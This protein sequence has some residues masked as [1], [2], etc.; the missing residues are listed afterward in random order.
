ML[1]YPATFWIVQNDSSHATVS[2][3][4]DITNEYKYNIILFGWSGVAFVS[5][6]SSLFAIF[7]HQNIV[8]QDGRLH[9]PL[10]LFHTTKL[11]KKNFLEVVCELEVHIKLIVLTPFLLVVN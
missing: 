10:K 6:S 4:Y 5:W 11:Q 2:Q 3:T 9:Q 1:I 7:I 8:F